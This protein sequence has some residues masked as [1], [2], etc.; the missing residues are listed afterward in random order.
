MPLSRSWS[1][2]PTPDLSSRC[3]EPMAPAQSTTCRPLMI[4]P[5]SVSIPTARVPWNTT[6]RTSVSVSMLTPSKRVGHRSVPPHA[7]HDV[8]R[9]WPVAGRH[10]SVLVRFE[11]VAELCGGGRERLRDRVILR[12]PGDRHRPGR[13][14]EGRVA[15]VEV[16]LEPAQ[17]RKTAFIGPLGSRLRPGFEVLGRGSH[18]VA[19][20]GRRR[21][22]QRSTSGDHPRS[23]GKQMCRPGPVRGM[24]V[25]GRSER[26]GVQ[27]LGVEGRGVDR[28]TAGFHQHDRNPRI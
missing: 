3:A 5:A 15:E 21:A 6:R 11:G 13:A 7:V 28:R 1:A 18:E 19:A 14:M 2:G 4:S 16:A 22:A 20:V 27:Q 8:H 12:G 25:A 24:P 10:R 23:V 17:E 26:A 9:Q